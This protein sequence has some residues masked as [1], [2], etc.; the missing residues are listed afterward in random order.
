MPVGP[1]RKMNSNNLGIHF[2]LQFQ[3]VV[4]A[5]CSLANF[6][7]FNLQVQTVS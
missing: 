3:Y 4:S 1:I 7:M 2:C 6:V 5:T